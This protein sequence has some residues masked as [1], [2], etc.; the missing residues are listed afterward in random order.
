MK[1]LILF[2]FIFSLAILNANIL[3]EGPYA[4]ELMWID[5]EWYLELSNTGVEPYSLLNCYI[6]NDSSSSY[7]LDVYFPPGGATVVTKDSLY[8]PFEFEIQSDEIILGWEFEPFGPSCAVHYGNGYYSMTPLAD[9]S[10]V[11]QYF[12]AP[13]GEVFA[14]EYCRDNTPTLGEF[15]DNT[16]ITGIF[17]GSITNEEGYPLAGAVIE[18]F[19]WNDENQ[20]ITD[21]SGN[22]SK[23][24]YTIRYDIQVIFEDVTYIDTAIC[25]A[26]DSVTSM[27]FVLP[28]TDVTPS[29]SI[30]KN[31][32]MEVFPNP[33]NP[34]TNI[35]F[36]IPIPMNE[37]LVEIFN[38]KGQKIKM[39][40][41]NSTTP[42]NPQ[43]VVWNGKNET[44]TP[45]ASGVYYARLKGDGIVLKESKMLLLK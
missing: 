15:N 13:W 10:L 16:G 6:Y 37:V 24:M 28:I 7:F 31:T 45:V 14:I 4:E 26:P 17:T 44:D 32:E 30:L 33:F 39:L 29:L 23:E 43:Q 40:N 36:D 35:M 1:Y 12:V 19:P 11:R 41:C 27:E 42:N 21:L 2:I 25:V 18:Y 34:S 8:N 9:E 5:G 22:F 20:I 3:I 38:S